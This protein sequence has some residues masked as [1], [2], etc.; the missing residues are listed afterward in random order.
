MN[1]FILS[2]VLAG[3]AFASDI[4]S[5]QF[6]HRRHILICFILSTLLLS[7][8]F[9]LLESYISS[10]VVFLSFLRV[11]VAYFRTDYRYIL[12]FSALTVV[13]FFGLQDF[14]ISSFLALIAGI[15]FSVAAFQPKDKLLRLYTML[16]MV[17][18]IPHVFLVGT[19]IGFSVE[20][21]F[22]L[23]NLVG[24]WRYYGKKTVGC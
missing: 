3:I 10:A 22:L 8:H 2:Q 11:V 7:A 5:F 4:A 18:W 24:Y 21:F 12:L 13:V 15:I 19:P 9:F 23:S 6:K 16:G 14:S 17:F 20:I 1:P